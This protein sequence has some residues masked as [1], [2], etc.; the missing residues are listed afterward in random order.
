MPLSLR[1]S[2]V[3]VRLCR[4]ADP[5]G[6]SS[7][8]SGGHSVGVPPVPIPN[9]VVKADSA[10][11]TCGATCRKNRSPPEYPVHRAR[12]E[13]SPR[14]G[15]SAFT[16]ACS[17]HPAPMRSPMPCTRSKRRQQARPDYPNRKPAHARTIHQPRKSYR[18]SLAEGE[19]AVSV[20]DRTFSADLCRCPETARRHTPPAAAL[21]D[22][23]L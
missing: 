11:D 10:D 17:A 16:A 18:E 20:R 19:H 23:A 22:A 2:V 15:R 9:T 5:G 12:F 6:P 8:L 13:T 21:S 14:G 7:Q 3:W 1:F 4:L